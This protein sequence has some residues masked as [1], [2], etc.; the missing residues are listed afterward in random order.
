MVSWDDGGVVMLGLLRE[1]AGES[2][3]EAQ[4]L[5]NFRKAIHGKQG[6]AQGSFWMTCCSDWH[7]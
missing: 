6:G 2:W 4:C 5:C 1:I 3:H 7:A